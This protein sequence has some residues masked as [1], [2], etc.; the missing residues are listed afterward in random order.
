MTAVRPPWSLN[1]ATA[2]AMMREGGLTPSTLLES[3]VARLTDIEPHLRSYVVVDREGAFRAAAT[4]DAELAQGKLRGSLHGIPIAIKDIFDVAGLPTKCGSRAYNDAPPAIEDSTAVA[5]L[6][7]AGAIIIGKTATHELACG[8]YTPPTRNPWNLDRIPGGSSGGSAAA[9][10]SG[11]AMGATGSDTGGS[12]RIPAA[13][14]G[15]VGLKPTYG[16]VSRAGVTALSW[17]LDH[18]GPLARTVEDAWVLLRTMAGADPRDP[19]TVDRSLP[20]LEVRDGLPVGCRIGIPREVFFDHLEPAV[21]S[22]MESVQRVLADLGAVFVHVS[23]PELAGALHA[24][25]SIVLAEAASYHERLVK[26][27]PALIGDEVRRLLYAGLMLPSVL[28]LRAQRLRTVLQLAFRS[29]FDQQRLDALLT[30]TLPATAARHDQLTYNFNG[31]EEDVTGTFVRT[32]APFN[33]TGLP[34]I[35]VPAGLSPDGLPIGMQLAGRPFAEVR[36]AAIAQTLE[37]AIGWGETYPTPPALDGTPPSARCTTG[38]RT[39]S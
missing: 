25:F 1:I 21:A 6:R 24:E 33:L 20:D 11:A 39:S 8:V 13:L 36:I 9:V 28:Y 32:T 35:T 14:C 34:A 17:S 19:T 27:Q 23:I 18:V 31:H 15:V 30:P 2:G 22:T 16:R 5:R 12:I 38:R 37:R 29:A 10:A 7:A 26:T 3:V 4:L